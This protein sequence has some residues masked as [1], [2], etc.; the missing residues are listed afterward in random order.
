MDFKTFLPD[1]NAVAKTNWAKPQ[2]KIDTKDP[3]GLA[4]L[5]GAVLMLIFVF[6]PWTTVTNNGESVSKLGIV[7]WFG[8]FAFLCAAVA[9]AGVLYNH[10]E[11]AFC[12]AVLAVLFGILGAVIVP[13]ITE[14]GI[15]LTGEKIK[16]M[17]E[18]NSKAS[19]S[20]WGAY[21]YLVASVVTGAAAYLKITKK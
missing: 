16:K 14:N 1:F 20:H 15:T 10:T 9:V 19:I 7:N 4:L 11:L 8:I 21:L 18:A 17:V 3:I 5:G 13:D 2:L 6:L 12:A